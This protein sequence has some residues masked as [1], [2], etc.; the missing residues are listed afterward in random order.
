MDSLKVASPDKIILAIHSTNNFFGF[1]YQILNKDSCN[2]NIF[3][4]KFDRDLTNNLVID[5]ESFL[6]NHD[7]NSIER[8]SVSLGPSNFNASRLIIVMARTLAQ[9][10]NCSLDNCTNFRLMAKRIAIKNNIYKCNQNFWIINKL[11]KRGFLAGKYSIYASNQ[12]KKSLIISEEIEPK[13]YQ[14]ISTKL[15]YFE[16]DLNFEDDLNELLN[17]SFKNYLQKVSNSWDCT[18]P[19]YP[20]SPTD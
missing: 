19:I 7:F 8:I 10:M 17:L 15:P 1:G 16:T 20:I 6:S 14:E 2:R 5:L 11:R 18:M 12:L 3:I 4:K 9:R 13:L